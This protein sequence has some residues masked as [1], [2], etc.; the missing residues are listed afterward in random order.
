MPNSS[1]LDLSERLIAALKTGKKT[2]SCAESCTGGLLA[3]AL[4]EIS[5]ASAVFDRGFVTYSN[6]AKRDL[7]D[8]PE[9][10]LNRYGA[11]SQ[12]TAIAMV[13]G[14]LKHSLADIAI[15]ITGIAGPEG[16]TAEKPVGT[17][18]IG[19]TIRGQKE[20]QATHHTFSG[21]RSSVR[22][23]SVQAAQKHAL[24]LLETA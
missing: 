9:E 24:S 5:G 16:G 21:N 18:W 10:T 3:A 2:F 1:E 7:L 6:A 23:Q 22:K 4:T 13:T 12:E 15:S 8:V 19:Y 14:V 11:V 17:V 20:P